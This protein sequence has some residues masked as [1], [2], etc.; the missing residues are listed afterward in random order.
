MA[1]ILG[2]RNLTFVWLLKVKYLFIISGDK[3]YFKNFCY[4]NPQV[5]LVYSDSVV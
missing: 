2:P 4:K 1:D 5:S 3:F